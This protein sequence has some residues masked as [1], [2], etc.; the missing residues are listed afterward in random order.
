MTDTESPAPTAYGYLPA[1]EKVKTMAELAAISEQ[2]HE[3]GR[4]VVLCHGV[5]DLVHLGHVRH[6]EAARREGE[7]LILTITADKFVNK[8]PGRPIFKE[9]MR[10]EMLAAL[11]Y[12]DWVGINYGPSAEPVL[13]AIK[14]DIYVKGSDYENPDDDITG[15]IN[16]ERE[17]VERH[18]GRVVFT[19]DITFSSS[20]LIN[21]YLDVYDPPL[22]DCLNN[23]RAD[24]GTDRI[25]A[26]IESVRGMKVL[27]VG[28][29][30]IDEYQYVFPLGKSAKE[31]IIATQYHSSEIFAGGVFAAA[32]HVAEFCAEV[33]IITTLGADCPYADIIRGS[34]KP[35]VTL[36]AVPV[37]GRPTT[38]KLRHVE[39]GNIR[40]LFEVYFM[41]DK[42][43]PKEPAENLRQ[44][45]EAKARDADLVVVTDFGHSLIG[46]GLVETLIANA[47]FLAV[48]AQTNSGNQGYNL[49]TKYR[50]ADYI[51]ID[52][53]E[54]RLACA[55][56]YSDV[57]KVVGE[58]LPGLVDCP[59]VVVT[60]GGSGCY[61]FNPDEGVTRV[62]AFTKTVVDTVGA[63]DAFFAVTAPMVAA[64][65]R[66]ADIGF[67]GNAAGAMKVGIVG[68]RK[69]VEK[70]PLMKFVTTLLK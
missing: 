63:G 47:R 16:S 33:E 58:I 68:H 44:L 32:N 5:F 17:A 52:A 36:T 43:L 51:C 56:R 30:I 23:L 7:V 8:G 61:T 34:L 49:I 65:G 3:E 66:M 54:A 4:T 15:K 59:H 26:L 35:N 31:N 38:R 46:N 20:N 64:G 12:V 69:S 27:F 45:V 53:P 9:A 60:H 29:A 19:K 57:T 22:R 50:K 10:A 11:E 42:P 24:G 18:G 39:H 2:A 67:I 1:R 14:P 28:D 13:D 21:S 70:V 40:K 6:I 41:D 48:N 25:P 37:A 62:P 55:D